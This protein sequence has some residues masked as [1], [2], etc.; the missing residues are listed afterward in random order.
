[1]DRVDTDELG[2]ELPNERQFLVDLLLAEVADVQ[3]HILPVGSVESPPLLDLLHDGPGQDVPRAELHLRGDVLLQEPLPLLV[4]QVA[5]LT[6]RGFGHED[7]GPR[8]A[9]GVV[10]DEFHVLQGHIRPVGQS[11]PV[12]GVDGR[13]G[14][15]REDPPEAARAQDHR[16]GRD[17]PDLGVTEVDGGDPGTLPVVHEQRRHEELVQPDDPLVLQ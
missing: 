16:L 7:P 5:A 4:D 12:A 3:V 10:L 6:S 2:R 17:A 9:G 13:I 11:H 15:E 1:M 8:K 14:G